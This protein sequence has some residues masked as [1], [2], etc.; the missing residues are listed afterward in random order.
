MRERDRVEAAIEKQRKKARQ[1]DAKRK[2]A[3]KSNEYAGRLGHQKATGT[4]QKRMYQAAKDMEKR[5][6][7]LEGIEAPDSI[8]AVRFRQEQG[9]GTPSKPPILG[10]RFQLELRQLHAL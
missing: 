9:P 5:L 10:R 6:E 2:A 3:K 4:K 8:R 1:V 7:A